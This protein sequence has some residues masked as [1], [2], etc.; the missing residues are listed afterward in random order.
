MA[1]PFQY[2]LKY[3]PLDVTFLQDLKTRRIMKACGA[4]SISVLICLLCYI[5]RD[6]GYF[7]KWDKDMPFLVAEELGIKEGAV[8]E[9]VSTAIGVGFFD[10]VMYEKYGILTSSGIQERYLFIM[11]K[12]RRK[13]VSFNRDFMLININDVINSVN[14][15]INPVNDVINPAKEKE[16]KGKEIKENEKREESIE[17]KRPPAPPTP[18]EVAGYIRDNGYTFDAETFYLFYKSRGWMLDGTPIPDWRALADLWQKREPNFQRRGGNSMADIGRMFEERNA[19][20][21]EGTKGNSSD[22]IRI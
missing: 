7:V 8:S 14:D 13:K 1:A 11:K 10:G 16:K 21:D 22:I 15:V 18:E 20:A 3:F 17:K 9:V 4:Q 6:D 2:G 12:S 5:Y 19:N